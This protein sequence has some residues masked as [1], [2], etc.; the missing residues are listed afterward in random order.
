MLN[1]NNNKI[2]N[3]KRVLKKKGII[4]EIWKLNKCLLNE[5]QNRLIEAHWFINVSLNKNKN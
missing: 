5:A 3:F 2:L 4:I 1:L